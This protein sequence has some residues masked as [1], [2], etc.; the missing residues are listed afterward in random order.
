MRAGGSSGIGGSSFASAQSSFN[1]NPS[2]KATP[3]RGGGLGVGFA[4]FGA[5][6][7]SATRKEDTLETAGE[8]N[9][10][11]STTNDFSEEDNFVPESQDESQDY[12]EVSLD[13]AD[14]DAGA[15]GN[16]IPEVPES[17]TA[18]TASS[19]DS[20]HTIAEETSPS[21]I[22]EGLEETH[23]SD[24]AQAEDPVEPVDED[25][26]AAAREDAD[27]SLNAQPV[28]DE[29]VTPPSGVSAAVHDEHERPVTTEEAGDSYEDPQGTAAAATGSPAK[30]KKKKKKTA[31]AATGS[32][33]AHEES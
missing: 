9:A 25:A 14:V 28:L 22:K 18:H 12:E 4:P 7:G 19:G 1:S 32:P 16:F 27:N 5:G 26:A 17:M 11:Q 31:A 6:R 33:V 2:A 21:G 13:A 23:V 3:A 8:Y 10:P 15:E 20:A 24:E 29:T 30:R